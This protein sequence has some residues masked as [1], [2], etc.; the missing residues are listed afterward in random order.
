MPALTVR[1]HPRL[2]AWMAGRRGRV[3][4][5]VLGA[6]ALAG[7]ATWAFDRGALPDSGA[8][9]RGMAQ[10]AMTAAGL[11]VRNVTVEGRERTTPEA[12]LAALGVA[13]GDPMAGFD[14]GGARE[15][16]EALPWVREA[17]VS[18]GLPDRI[19]VT[20]I[21]RRPFALWQRRG[22]LA[23]V[24]R[25]GV[26]VAEAGVGRFSG[27]PVLVGDDA[28]GHASGLMDLL[29][30]EP[31]LMAVV[32]AAVRVGG[33]RW[34]IHLA[35]G[36]VVRLPETGAAAAWHRLA[37]LDR[38]YQ[39][40]ARDVEII[41]LRLPGRAAVRLGDGAAALLRAPAEDA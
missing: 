22:T 21:E 7:A 5:S 8:I 15:R 32:R 33:R 28:V 4:A 23:V 38:D 34:D 25:D 26:V 13:R 19:R 39:L 31:E 17:V 36:V 18:R 24:D 12:V 29:S 35:T 2:R 11:T 16:I 41:D 27:L 10:S 37:S 9:T 6:V 1:K 3:V 20:L 40:L 14:P 30:A